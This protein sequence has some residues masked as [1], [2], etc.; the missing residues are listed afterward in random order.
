MKRTKKLNIKI[1]SKLQN[2]RLAKGYTQEEVA[3]KLDC[4]SRYIGQLE[5]DRSQGSIDL[6]IEL[7]NLYNITL[8]DLY[9][10]Y[11]ILN[12]NTKKDDLPN[13]VGY[14]QLSNEY[15]SI[16]DNTISF[17]INM[18]KQTDNHKD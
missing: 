10:N 7:C 8:D 14:S 11:L 9:S 13:I 15:R 5:T 6:I 2:A 18:Q 17:L 16:I 1:G 3:E 12:Y 4:S